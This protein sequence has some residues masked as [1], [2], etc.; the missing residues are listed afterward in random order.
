MN[1]IE[2]GALESPL[3]LFV[4]P[5]KNLGLHTILVN[6]IGWFQMGFWN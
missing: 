2:L 1:V 6:V 4:V 5:L 3:H